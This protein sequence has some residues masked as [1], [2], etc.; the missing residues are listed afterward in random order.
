MAT[1]AAAPADRRSAERRF[2]SRMAMLLVA[3]VLIGFAPSFYLRDIVPSYPRPNPTL[4]ASVLLHGGLFT[5]WMLVFVAQTQLV[6]AGRLGVHMKLGKASMVLAL[7]IIPMMYLAAVWQVA[8]ANQPPFTDP[9]NWTIVPLAGIP[10]YAYLVWTGW[11]RRKQAQWHKRAMLAAAILVVM[12]PAVGRLPI[13]PPTLGGFAFQMLVGLAL[14]VPLLL[15]DRRSLGHVHP[16]TWLG[17]VLGAASA[18][19]PIVLIATGT[20]AP[21]ARHLPGVGG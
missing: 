4:P 17:L 18:F 5:A 9:L 6:A 20:W 21:I 19:I 7:A 2:Y 11:R 10:A 14:F 12:G 16:A 13:A 15:W 1:V 3:L 8:R